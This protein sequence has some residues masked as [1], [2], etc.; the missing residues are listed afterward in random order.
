MV[1]QETIPE[2]PTW[3]FS[4]I[5][6]KRDLISFLSLHGMAV[7]LNIA[8]H[9]NQIKSYGH[10]VS[11]MDLRL[12]LF[13]WENQL[14]SRSVQK[15][16]YE[17]TIHFRFRRAVEKPQILFCF[18]REL[19]PRQWNT[20]RGAV[21]PSIGVANTRLEPAGS[22]LPHCEFLE[23]LSTKNFQIA[24]DTNGTIVNGFI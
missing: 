15:G 24:S 9:R 21:R 18:S 13:V 16:P 22:C 12:T 7:D 10:L 11:R 1:P 19:E 20:L 14:R 4:A 2:L 6:S 23:F 17:S 3:G 8:G 5:A